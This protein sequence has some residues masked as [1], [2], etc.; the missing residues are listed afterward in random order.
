MFN[1]S[2][3]YLRANGFF[4]LLAIFLALG[5]LNEAKAN[6]KITVSTGFSNFGELKYSKDFDHLEY[7]NP[8]APKGGE[9]SI[10]ANGTFDSM[11]PYSRK[12]TSGSLSSIFF[13]EL[14]TSTADEIGTVYCFMCSSL[15]YPE[16]LSWVVFNLRPEVTFSDGSKLTAEDVSF[17]YKLFLTE[18]L[19]SFRAVL[20][21][22]VEKVEVLESNKIKF[23]FL[24]DAPLRDRIE[25]VGGLPV[26][27]QKW[28][29]EN[30]A[31][32]DESRL[33]PALGTGPYV[34]DSYDI[35]QE[36]LYKRNENY[37]ARDLNFTKGRNN[38]DYIRVEYFGDSNAAF[39]GFKSGAYTFRIENSSKQWATGY[40][41]PALNKGHIVKRELRDGTIA[42]GQS[43]AMNLRKEKFK[44]IKVRE[45][46]SLMFNFEWSNT[47]LFYGLY[48]RINSFWENSDLAAIGV[49][50]GEE[51]DLLVELVD[52]G[53]LSTEILTNLVIS[54][55][56]SGSRQLDRKNLRAASKLL[57]DAGWVV[58]DDGKRRKEGKTLDVEFLEASP[59]FDRIVN[60]F[61]EN[62][63]SL[64]VNAKLNR[65]DYA[66]YTNRT[67]S[68]DFDIVTDQFRMSYEPG[69]GLKQYFGSET[70]KESLFNSMGVSSPA[71]DRL[72]D[73]ISD[74][75]SKADLRIAV[76]ALDRVLRAEKFWIPQWYKDVHT[77]AYFDMFEHPEPL[78]PYS[79]GYLDFWWV[80]PEKEAKLKAEGAL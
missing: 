44:D 80:N 3:S 52:E 18:G 39:E 49:P 17:S 62:L 59:A 34:L 32:L 38:F 42:T 51:L 67:R 41:F 63:I 31:G 77:V 66:Q 60:P 46:L 20:S 14:L 4:Q 68:F 28:F 7:V 11:N 9:I 12:G 25:T 76:R 53:L 33:E 22:L 8:S 61:V 56:T 55:P 40:D 64:G 75:S 29:T 48:A 78:P 37:W 24:E 45:A 10:W 16:D 74:A 19:V 71:I 23:Y 72:I 43:F 58:G 54:A 13:E 5:F 73:I 36:I 30:E 6:E 1:F 57:D 27:S 50:E 70:A 26:F 35:N 2:Y 79:L 15:E 21:K 65:I 69:S 47:T